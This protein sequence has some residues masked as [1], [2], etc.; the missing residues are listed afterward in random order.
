[1]SA[2]RFK[3]TKTQWRRSS[4]SGYCGTCLRMLKRLYKVLD[5]ALPSSSLSWCKWKFLIIFVGDK[6]WKTAGQFQNQKRKPWQSC[7]IHLSL[8]WTHCV[9]EEMS[10]PVW[11]HPVVTALKNPPVHGPKLQL[12]A[13][14]GATCSHLALSISQPGCTGKPMGAKPASPKQSFQTRNCFVV[15]PCFRWHRSNNP[16][17]EWCRAP[18]QRCAAARV[19]PNEA[20]ATTAQESR[21]QGPAGKTA[22]AHDEWCRQTAGCL[23][24][25]FLKTS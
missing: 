20:T 10:C 3:L 18:S 16:G 8:G 25:A 15:S 6:A 17:R 1:M 2:T 5:L 21:E 13:T 14:G 12:A 22:P 23:V 4:Q 11:L 7:R 19:L 9:A 24:L